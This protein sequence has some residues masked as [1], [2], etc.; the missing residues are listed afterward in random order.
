MALRQLFVFRVF[1]FCVFVFCVILA[2]TFSKA[3]A[4]NKNRKRDPQRPPAT[5][6]TQG[7]G[8]VMTPVSAPAGAPAEA[9][10]QRP[11][12]I[13]S[14]VTLADVGYADGFRLANL[15]GRREL[16]VPLPEG[17]EIT[18][19]ELVLAIDDVTAHDARRSLEVLLNDRSVAA[20]PLDGKSNGRIVRIPLKEARPREG[21]LKFSFL[22]SGAATPDRCIDV[23]YVGD[24]LT[25]RPETA[26]ELDIVFQGTPDVATTA[27][28]M[29]REVAIV[30]PNRRLE[31]ADIASALTVARSLA[32]SGRRASFHQGFDKLAALAR[33][34]DRRWAMGIVAVGGLHEI[35]GHLDAPVATIAGPPTSFGALV[36]GRVG[37]MPVLVVSDAS[38]A[39]AAR[40][41]AS[42]T[43]K[44]ARG[45]NAVTIGD[46]SVP[47]ASAG[48]VAFESLG[49]VLP[50]AEVF[51]RADLLAA[52]DMRML[53]A[54][55]RPARLLLDVM[56]APDGAGEKAVV[57]AFVNDRLLG[58]T[59]AA[60]GEPTKLD[61]PLAD[62][63]VGTH[64]SV[65]V[66]VQRRSAQGDCRFE[67]Q[68]YPA[69]ILGSSAVVLEN[70]NARA[71][72]FY[73]LVA[74]FSNGVE[75]LVPPRVGER[76]L[77]ALAL[78]GDVLVALTP[79][80]SAIAV[81]MVAAVTAPAPSAPF[82]AV[83]TVAPAGSTPRVRFDRG[84]VAVA[85]RAGQTVLDLGG[86]SVGAVAQV[87]NAGSRPGLW[88]APLTDDG[89]LPAPPELKL[90]RGDVAFLDQRG[91]ALSLST[92]RNT[93]VR[94]TY[95][96]QVS[97]LSVADR[98][99]PW[100][101]GSLWLIATIGFLF[102]LQRIMRR[103][104]AGAGD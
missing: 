78:L 95:P 50:Q 102:V 30:V 52:I 85:D 5:T 70:A 86:L 15:G 82:I 89:S 3:E 46:I 16:F 2:L 8:P 31:P 91:V 88:I 75:I 11:G 81:K 39:R 87:V 96:D 18:A 22:Y 36:A 66:V 35:I 71:R 83:G 64:A 99:R 1:V 55:M 41:L 101:I 104:P 29:P 48:Q 93:L 28:L 45:V 7:R 26:V 62:G 33:R 57:S 24:S 38:S 56:V 100:I 42:P 72:D 51:G 54:G 67:P 97:W 74:H 21:F 14:A 6:E 19:R 61:L 59:V 103:R 44:A 32:A 80:T 9:V 37:G 84:R 53:P 20:I 63:L 43:L 69:Q 23:R 76:P 68:G 13:L 58:S 73:D 60:S 90:D 49:I 47:R 98:F 27:A 65:R 4:E 12:A 77:A 94:V 34:E 25:V 79:E 17:A 40:L 10:R 92:E